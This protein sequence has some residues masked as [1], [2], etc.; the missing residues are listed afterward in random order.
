MILLI[1]LLL[2]G[3]ASAVL[4]SMFRR[5]EPLWFFIAILTGG[6]GLLAL[7]ILCLIQFGEENKP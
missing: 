1:F 4:A 2:I 5:S 6:W 3:W 7:A